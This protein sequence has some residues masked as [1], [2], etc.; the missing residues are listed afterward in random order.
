MPRYYKNKIYTDGQR[1]TISNHVEKTTIEKHERQAKRG[2]TIPVNIRKQQVDQSF[3]VMYNN[4]ES[5]RDT[6]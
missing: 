1:Q 3:E 4:A 5:D 2:E 6:I